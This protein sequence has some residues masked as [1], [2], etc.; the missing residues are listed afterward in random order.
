MID[1]GITVN[2]EG[3]PTR[4]YGIGWGEMPPCIGYLEPYLIAPVGMFVEIRILSNSGQNDPFVQT[5][6]VNGITKISQSNFV[7]YDDL[8]LDHGL[9]VA[10]RTKTKLDLEDEIDPENRIFLCTKTNVYALTMRQFYLQAFELQ[11]NKEFEQA[12]HICEIVDGTKY[13]IEQRR[14]RSIHLDY[15]YQLFAKGEFDLSMHHFKLSNDDPRMV[16]GLFPDLLP[17]TSK[18]YKQMAPFSPD[19]KAKVDKMLKDVEQRNNA[20]NALIQYLSCKRVPVTTEIEKTE[21]QIAEAVDTAF[22]KALLYS[23]DEFV[24]NFLQN[25]NRCIIADSERVLHQHKKFA[26]LVLFYKSKGLHERALVLLKQL[27]KGDKNKE[28]GFTDL[29]GVRPT[30]KYLQE[31]KGDDKFILKFSRWVLKREPIL[32]LKIFQ[33]KDCPFDIYQVLDHLESINGQKNT[34]AIAYLE[35]LI[36]VEKMTDSELHN[37]LIVLYLNYI[38]STPDAREINPTTGKPTYDLGDV[39]NRLKQF[40]SESQ[41]YNAERML[42]K[43]PF[44]S[45]YEER[46]ILLSRINRHSQALNIYVHKLNRPDLAEEYC[47]KHFDP[48]PTAPEESREIFITLLRMNLQPPGSDESPKIDDAIRLLEKHHH[49]ID[50]NKALRLLPG[51]VPVTKL[52]RFLESVLRSHVTKRRTLQVTKNLSRSENLQ[53]Q[54]KHIQERKR[55]VK[56]KTG[57]LCQVCNRPLGLSAFACYP[58]DV[59]V[60]YVCTKNNIHVCPVT[61]KQFLKDEISLQYSDFKDEQQ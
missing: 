17:S 34:M 29:N 10:F 56:I 14:V 13:Q 33:T 19:E 5:V 44:A 41:H 52:N 26:E 32:G 37:R 40:L 24:T 1:I 53:V 45:L 4:K 31:L 15:A 30:I 57:R 6:P 25:P 61:G 51:D 36:R 47:V 23:N 2:F 18:S 42:S 49:K 8:V 38:T 35:H 20:L 16:L 12:L 55:V 54:E 60:H 7:D 46:A 11:Q 58:N 48:S 43:F 50:V 9:G 27:G 59:V 21:L 28:V 22:L 3:K 39:Q